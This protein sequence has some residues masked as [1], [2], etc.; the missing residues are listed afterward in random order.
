[1]K[2]W[3]DGV[4]VLVVEDERPLATAIRRTLESEGFT[5]VL[6]EDGVDGE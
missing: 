4:R 3:G 6:A 5:V 1:M 2:T